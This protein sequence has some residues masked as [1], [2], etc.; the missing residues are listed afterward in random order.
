MNGLV[1]E[2][3]WRRQASRRTR[4]R[5]AWWGAQYLLPSPKAKGLKQDRAFRLFLL[6][7]SFTAAALLPCFVSRR[8][9]DEIAEY[10]LSAPQTVSEP[11]RV[12]SIRYQLP[13]SLAYTEHTFTQ[14]Q[15]FRGKLLL[16]D[17]AHP[18]PSAAP[19]P[20]TFS[21]ASQG[22]GM[23]NVRSLSLQSGRTTIS[24]LVEL[25]E[26]LRRQGV[27]DVT[28][29]RATQSRAQLRA[30]QRAH[31]RSLMRDQPPD[32]A[33]QA[34]WAAYSFAA[35]EEL[36]QEYTV[37]LAVPDG[38][39]SEQKLLQTAWRYGFV[40]THPHAD[41]QSAQLFR[42]VGVAHATAM[43]YLDVDFPTYLEWLHRKGTLAIYQGDDLQYLILCKPLTG[44]HI[45]FALPAGTDYEVSADNQG[46]AIATA[47]LRPVPTTARP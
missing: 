28:V 34:V 18:L 24:A 33:R 47:G 32:E 23:I 41:T 45:T 42:Y 27:G 15:L 3:E 26:A 2:R 5:P 37:E 39:D 20:N 21:I 31:M 43:T 38:S 7:L 8:A 25:F 44:T 6:L 11:R 30:D 14:E 13:S 10:P 4:R 19:P 36:L 40:R 16:L 1:T 17:S 46:Y 9:A 12:S 29:V 22:R 35:Q